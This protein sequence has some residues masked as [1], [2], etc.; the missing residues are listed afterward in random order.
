[1]SENFGLSAFEYIRDNANRLHLEK[2]LV[3]GHSDL[4]AD[5][6][7]CAKLEEK[8]P[9]FEAITNG[10]SRLRVVNL[11]SNNKASDQVALTS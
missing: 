6:E 9:S 11:H 5:T 4:M 3:T 10:I 1:M 8:L 2:V 7:L